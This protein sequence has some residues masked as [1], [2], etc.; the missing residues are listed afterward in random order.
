MD[1]ARTVLPTPRFPAESTETH[2]LPLSCV[3]VS[4]ALGQQTTAH[5]GSR[6]AVVHSMRTYKSVPLLAFD[7]MQPK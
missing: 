5:Q 7:D 6:S 2:E 4:P 3:V 1:D